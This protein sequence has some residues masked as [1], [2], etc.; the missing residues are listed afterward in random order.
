MHIIYLATGDDR[1]EWEDDDNIR[2]ESLGE[3]GELDTGEE[4]GGE[5]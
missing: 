4:T 1:G 5:V 3:T 2:R